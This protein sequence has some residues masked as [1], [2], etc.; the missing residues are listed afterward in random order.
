MPCCREKQ[1]FLGAQKYHFR[2]RKPAFSSKKIRQQ[3]QN[4]VGSL[5]GDKYPRDKYKG[6]PVP[7]LSPCASAHLSPLAPAPPSPRNPSVMAGLGPAI[8]ALLPP[9]S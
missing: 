4:S 9:K 2:Q 3:S 6:G 8:H 1:T 5:N 7:R